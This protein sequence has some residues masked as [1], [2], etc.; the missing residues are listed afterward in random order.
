MG[1]S[2]LLPLSILQGPQWTLALLC[3][4]G[5]E[6]LPVDTQVPGLSHFWI[7]SL[8]GLPQEGQEKELLTG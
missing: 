3:S 1:L 4:L 6:I 8:T 5:V 2:N 7:P